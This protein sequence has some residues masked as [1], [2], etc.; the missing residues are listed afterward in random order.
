MIV[1]ETAKLSVKVLPEKA[2]KYTT[3][4]SS[5]EMVA[6]INSKGVLTAVGGGTATITVTSKNG[7]SSSV[8]VTVDGSKHLMQLKIDYYRDDDNNIGD[9]WSHTFEVNGELPSN[10]MVLSAK[11]KLSFFA[12]FTEEDDNPDVGEVKK[13][14]TVKEGDLTNGF[15]ITMDLKVKE[16]GGKN[17]GKAARFIITFSFTPVKGE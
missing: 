1:G 13:T 14:Y 17:R 8:D 9:E 15:E 5:N 6:T 11:D 12:R 2:D 4:L 10:K 16:N 7:V 3:L